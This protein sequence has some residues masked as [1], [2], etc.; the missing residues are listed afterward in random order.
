MSKHIISITKEDSIEH[1][2]HKFKTNKIH[3]LPVVENG[4]I[5]GIVSSS[6]LLFLKR[7]F[8][9]INPNAESER[10]SKYKAKDIMTEK[11]AVLE[12]NEKLN[13]ALEIF[14][15]N[16]FHAIPI[17]ENKELVGMITPYDFIK[18]LDSKEKVVSEYLV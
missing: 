7:G 10:L 17:V 12:S 16:L 9:K 3:H 2:E 18:H 15:E 11:L 4:E 13:I 14:K 5:I 8:E 6:D 1:I